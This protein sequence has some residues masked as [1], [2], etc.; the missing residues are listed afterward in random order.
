MLHLRSRFRWSVALRLTD[1]V[2]VQRPKRNDAKSPDYLSFARA[3]EA[4][5]VIVLKQPVRV[6]GLFG[7]DKEVTRIGLFLDDV[8][9]FRA[10]LDQQRQ[11]PQSK[12]P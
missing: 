4:H 5:M 3:G 1:I 2:D 9:A 6:N 11:V 12:L 10:E 7:I 8:G